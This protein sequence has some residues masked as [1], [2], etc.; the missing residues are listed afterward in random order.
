V[1]GYTVVQNS[2]TKNA[3]SRN[4]L[5][6]SDTAIQKASAIEKRDASSMQEII[7]LSIAH[8]RLQ[9][10]TSNAT[11]QPMIKAVGSTYIVYHIKTYQKPF[12]H[13]GGRN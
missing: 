5:S 13:Y 8:A 1:L 7:R 4:A 11:T 9:P 3:K 10:R 6:A 12:P 2:S